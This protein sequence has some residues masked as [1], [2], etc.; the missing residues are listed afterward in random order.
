MAIFKSKDET[1]WRS[2]TAALTFFYCLNFFIKGRI[3]S[4]QS[5][6]RAHF[7][8]VSTKCSRL[9]VSNDKKNG[10]DCKI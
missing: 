7:V 2:E 10:Q 8:V 5:S 4:E 9:H 1:T 6:V 3:S